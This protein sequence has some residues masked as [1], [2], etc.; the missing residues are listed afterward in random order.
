LERFGVQVLNV[1][2]PGLIG[3]VFHRVQKVMD[4]G[5]VA[6]MQYPGNILF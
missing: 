5:I 3:A 6:H 1:T 4:F 2:A